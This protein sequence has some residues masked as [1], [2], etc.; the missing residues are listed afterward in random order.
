MTTAAIELDHV[1]KI[2]RRYSGRQFSTLKS[3]IL[4]RSLMH[5]LRPNEVLAAL[6]DVSFRVPA[7]S[8]FGVVGSQR[9]GQEHGAEAHRRHHEADERHG[10]RRRARV[11]A[12]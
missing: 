7:G 5:D 12:D 8:T 2:Y 6:T 3:A 10:P 1:S 11:G 4:Q 9:I